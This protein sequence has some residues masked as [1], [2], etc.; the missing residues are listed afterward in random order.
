[1]TGKILKAISGFYYVYIEGKGTYECRAKGVFRQLGVKPLVGDYARI[2]IIDEVKKTGNVEEIIPRRNSLIRPAVANIDMALVVF[3]AAYPDPNLNLLDRFLITMSRQDIP[4]T[5]VFNKTELVDD[6]TV[7]MMREA[8][9]PCGYTCLF[10]SVYEDRGVD[11]VLS[12]LRGK[13]STIAGPSGVGK[14]SLIQK[15]A[16]GAQIETGEVSKKIGRGKQTTRHTEIIPLGNSTYIMDTPGFSSLYVTDIGSRELWQYY[17]EFR[18]Y[19]PECKF[20][21]CSHISEPSCGIKRALNDGLLSPV[22]YDNYTRIY[23]ECRAND[24]AY[25]KRRF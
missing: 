18:Q 23:E 25:S 24:A 21:G 16:P 5:I 14:S 10:I 1:M 15:L 9:E 20:A 8:Y 12:V 2:Q 17:S 22:R 4:V 11:E 3:A 7:E 6:R 19:E 13:T